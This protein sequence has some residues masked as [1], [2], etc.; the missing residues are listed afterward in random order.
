MGCLIDNL[1]KNR[2]SNVSFTLNETKKKFYK[3]IDDVKKAVVPIETYYQITFS[4]GDIATIVEIVMNT[5][6]RNEQ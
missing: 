6:R 1:K 5:R 2:G 3:Q 4:E